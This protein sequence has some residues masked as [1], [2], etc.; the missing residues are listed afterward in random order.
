M[1]PGWDGGISVV[2][3]CDGGILAW[4][5]QTEGA[6]QFQTGRKEDELLQAWMEG[7]QLSQ[8]VTKEIGCTRLG[9]RK[10][11]GSKLGRRDIGDFWL[12]GGRREVGNLLLRRRE[13]GWL[14]QDGRLG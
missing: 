14:K 10:L 1:V 2:L 9:R 7:A 4:R 11:G 6:R 12:G 3:G 13:F 5:I 8:A